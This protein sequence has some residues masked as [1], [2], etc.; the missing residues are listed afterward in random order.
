M[1]GNRFKFFFATETQ[2]AQRLMSFVGDCHINLEE[3]VLNY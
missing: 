1:Q 2:S 3:G